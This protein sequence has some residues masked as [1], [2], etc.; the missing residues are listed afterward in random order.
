[1]LVV[2]LVKQ[3]EPSEDAQERRSR[4]LLLV[5]GVMAIAAM[6][7]AVIPQVLMRGELLSSL[8]LIAAG[9]LILTGIWSTAV[10]SLA[11]GAVGGGIVGIVFALSGTIVHTIDRSLDASSSLKLML[12][13]TIISSILGSLL[14]LAG[15]LIVW[16]VRLRRRPSSIS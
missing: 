11:Y 8:T 15:G 7:A 5:Y 14:A 4:Q 6:A 1:M 10:S 13:G 2:G 3:E 9:L 12:A 16:A